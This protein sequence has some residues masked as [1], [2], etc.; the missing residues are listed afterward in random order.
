MRSLATCAFTFG[1]SVACVPAYGQQRPIE[2]TPTIS[3]RTDLVLLPV[4]VVDQKG[5][6]VPGLIERNFTVHD[7]GALRPIEFFTSEDTP[8]TVGLVIDSSS[9]MRAVRSD[10]TAAGTAFAAS[11]H[12]LDELFTVNFNDVVWPGLAPSVASAETLE[13]LHRELAL[14]PARGMTALYD[15]LDDALDRLQAGTRDRKVLIVVS[16]GGDNAS[17]H[18]LAGVIAKA[19]ASGAV[20]YGVALVDPDDP[21]ARPAVLKRLARVTG[22]EMFRPGRVGD[23]AKVFTHIADAIR[24]GYTIGVVP[25][26][27]A[28]DS[29]HTIRV[30]VDTGDRRRLV[31]RTRA[32]YYTGPVRPGPR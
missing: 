22:G 25:P 11:S 16:D 27:D 20:I 6:L 19:R 18:T 30:T 26:D 5:A 15:A 9:S 12:P 1:L 29:F 13:R 28:P 8:A 31:A 4:T 23:I 10:V 14:A 32:G 21:A 17:T 2:S 3:V 24:S 7:N